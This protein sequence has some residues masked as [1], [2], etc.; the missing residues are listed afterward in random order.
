MAELIVQRVGNRRQ[1]REFLEFP[2]DALSQRSLLDPAAA[3]QPEGTGR[4]SAAPV[5]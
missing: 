3:G 5:L 4:L 2:L 1:R